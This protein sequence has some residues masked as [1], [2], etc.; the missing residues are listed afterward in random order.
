MLK[1]VTPSG[2]TGF[3]PAEA[4]SP[5]G[6]DQ[7]CYSKEGRRLEDL[8]LHRRRPVIADQDWKYAARAGIGARR[9]LFD[10]LARP[11]CRQRDSV[12]RRS[13]A[14]LGPRQK[15]QGGATMT[16]TALMTIGAASLAAARLRSASRPQAQAQQ[17]PQIETKKVDGT[18]NVY[19]FRNGNHQSMF[20]VT[21][22]RRDRDRSGRLRPA[23]R[24]PAICRRDQEGHRQADQVPGL[25]PPSLRPHRRR[26]GVQG[27]RRARS[28]RTRTRRRI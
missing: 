25:Q 19:I 1:V 16:R 13:I 15:R 22:G 27:C 6:N 14:S 8:G 28:S 7:L 20:V 23:D 11:R 2:K 3:V 17:R 18:D 26:Q 4:L 24:R 5:L 21:H 10:R 9:L 12:T